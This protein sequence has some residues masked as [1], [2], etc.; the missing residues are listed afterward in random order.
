MKTVTALPA[1]ALSYKPR[2]KKLLIK[3]IIYLTS[4]KLFTFASVIAVLWEWWGVCTD[5]THTIAYGAMAW[6][7]AFTPW[8]CDRQPATSVKTASALNNGKP[9]IDKNNRYGK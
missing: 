2:V 7:A 9:I 1:P 3:G 6:L 5:D 4:E 8:A